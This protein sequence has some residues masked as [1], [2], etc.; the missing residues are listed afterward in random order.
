MPRNTSITLGEHFES[1]ISTQIKE[2]RFNSKSEVVRAAM[3]LLEEHEQGFQE[4]LLVLRNKLAIG[5]AQLEAGQGID[6]E[7]FMKEL[8]DG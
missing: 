1:F 8:I 6:G 2:G 7:I 4:K 5:D 3:R